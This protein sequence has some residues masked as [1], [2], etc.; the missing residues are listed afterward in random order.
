MS[1]NSDK[2]LLENNANSSTQE[3]FET[4]SLTKSSN[5]KNLNHTVI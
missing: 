4:S 2:Y 5:S 1:K 3:N